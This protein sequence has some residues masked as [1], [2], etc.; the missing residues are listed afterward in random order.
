MATILGPVS[1]ALL[2]PVDVYGNE[3]EIPTGKGKDENRNRC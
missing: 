2:K 1:W 3:K